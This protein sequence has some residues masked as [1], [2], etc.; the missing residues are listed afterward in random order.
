M[1]LYTDVQHM[2]KSRWKDDVQWGK[3]ARLFWVQI[4]AAELRNE[5]RLPKHVFLHFTIRKN[6][7]TF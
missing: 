2:N 6:C 1:V 4:G 7:G 3:V 5:H